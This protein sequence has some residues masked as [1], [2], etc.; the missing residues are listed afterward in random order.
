MIAT[1]RL[2]WHFKVGKRLSGQGALASPANVTS[3]WPRVPSPKPMIPSLPGSSSLTEGED[4]TIS[5]VPCSNTQV[6]AARSL[7]AKAVVEPPQRKRGRAT[8]DLDGDSL[9]STG[10]RRMRYRLEQRN[11]T[12]SSSAEGPGAPPAHH[13][14]SPPFTTAI[15]PGVTQGSTIDSVLS[16]SGTSNAPTTMTSWVSPPDPSLRTVQEHQT[17]TRPSQPITTVLRDT[18]PRIGPVSGGI[19]IRLAVD[20]LPTT[21]TLYA[22]F[23][24]QVTATV[25]PIFHPL[26]LS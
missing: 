4:Q 20:D 11:G 17:S 26:S 15:G 23:G 10:R 8:A 6:L 18:N 24:T 22:R 21:F 1:C 3:P 14:R 13:S 25:S 16:S 2:P 5:V 9:G 12:H 7:G 19:E